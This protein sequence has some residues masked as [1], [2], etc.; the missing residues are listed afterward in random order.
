M[1]DGY[2]EVNCYMITEKEITDNPMQEEFVVVEGSR[3]RYLKAGSAKR[4]LVLIHGLGASAER[5][6]FGCL[7]QSSSPLYSSLGF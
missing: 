2:L 7:R 3:I 1:P 6:M 5:W 4:N